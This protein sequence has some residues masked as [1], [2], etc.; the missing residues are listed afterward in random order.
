[1]STK[2][3][4]SKYKQVSDRRAKII[5]I[6]KNCK[7]ATATEL[8]CA[9]NVSFNT[10]VHDMYYLRRTHKNIGARQGVGYFYAEDSTKNTG[11]KACTIDKA[12]EITEYIK[13]NVCVAQIDLIEKFSLS[14]TSITRYTMYIREADNHIVVFEGRR[15]R[16]CY[17]DRSLVLPSLSDMRFDDAYYHT[18]FYN[19]IKE[20]GGLTLDELHDLVGSCRS[21]LY[22]MS[23]RLLSGKEIVRTVDGRYYASTGVPEGYI[24]GLNKSD[25]DLVSYIRK[26][27][28]V[29]TR[30]LMDLIGTE[31][32]GTLSANIRRI[33]EFVTIRTVRKGCR[34]YYY[35]EP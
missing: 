1:M 30:E 27:G 35:T 16:I 10:I 34:H 31:Y 19:I 12:R 14:H 7:E 6:L 8:A 4:Y 20:N 22:T 25:N 2:Y 18:Q 17:E 28:T 32:L 3:E 33:R 11:M 24:I 5:E 29:S 23:R 15:G 13:E 9:L 26:H 21:T